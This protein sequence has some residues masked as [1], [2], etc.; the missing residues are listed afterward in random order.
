AARADALA[1]TVAIRDQIAL[2]VLR[3]EAA[4]HPGARRQ[5]GA[6]RATE[7]AGAATG[8]DLSVDRTVAPVVALGDGVRLRRPS[9]PLR[10]VSDSAAPVHREKR[11]E[12]GPSH[13]HAEAAQESASRGRL[14]DLA[15][16]ALHEFVELAGH[17][18]ILLPVTLQRL[19]SELT[20]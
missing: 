15:R 17:E 20:H 13:R 5:G 9:V 18:L 4:R 14:G 2:A 16:Q 8:A 7:Q 19:R 12:R 1:A 6:G 3:I 10:R 11:Q